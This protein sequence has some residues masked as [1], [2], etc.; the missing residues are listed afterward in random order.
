MEAGDHIIVLLELHGVDHP[1][2]GNPLIFHRSGFGK[3]AQAV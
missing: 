2:T 1:E 3:L